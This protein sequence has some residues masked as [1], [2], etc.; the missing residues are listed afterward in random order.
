MTRISKTEYY[1]NIAREIAKRS[2]CSRRKFGAIL[3]KNDSIISTGYNGT[4]PGALNCG[5]DIPCIKDVAEEPHYTS[6]DYCPALHAEENAVLAIG[7]AGALGS[8][9]YLAPFDSGDGDRPCYQC[10]RRLIRVGVED[11]Y[12]I[13]KEGNIKYELVSDW[14][15]MENDWMLAKLEEK[16]PNWMELMLE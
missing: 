13:D 11:C 14:I 4:T 8:T 15:D 2:P 1:L 6:Y 5:I 10:R 3:V 16:N 12:Y 9:L 7:R